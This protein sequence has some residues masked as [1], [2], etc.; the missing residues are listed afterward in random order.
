MEAGERKEKREKREREREGGSGGNRLMSACRLSKENASLKWKLIS[1]NS[2]GLCWMGWDR[3]R[4]GG[5]GVEEHQASSYLE[6]PV[7]PTV[8][9]G[10]DGGVHVAAVQTLQ[11]E[12]GN[13]ERGG[14]Y[15]VQPGQKDDLSARPAAVTFEPLTPSS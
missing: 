12:T 5:E 11:R 13:T 14:Y 2:L 9:G 1:C 15:T 6:Q 7:A 4:G 3:W 8:E 10:D